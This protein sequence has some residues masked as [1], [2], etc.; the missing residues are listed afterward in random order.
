[1]Y[2]R[3][4]IQWTPLCLS[5]EQLSFLV[6]F[7]TAFLHLL[8]CSFIGVHYIHMCVYVFYYVFVQ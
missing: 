1:M 5:Q 2:V 7:H 4:S 3:L 6:G 8:I